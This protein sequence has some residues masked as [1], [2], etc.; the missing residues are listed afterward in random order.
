LER[1]SAIVELNEAN[2]EKVTELER[3]NYE[4]KYALETQAVE[5]SRLSVENIRL[6]EKFRKGDE[7]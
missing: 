6:E 5:M 4:L 1:Y 7:A 2:S 3:E